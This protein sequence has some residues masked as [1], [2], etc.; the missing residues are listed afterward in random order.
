[1]FRLIVIDT[2][3]QLWRRLP[4]PEKDPRYRRGERRRNRQGEE[5]CIP[6]VA[7]QYADVDTVGHEHDRRPSRL[8]HV[9]TAWG[10]LRGGPPLRRKLFRDEMQTN[11]Y[12]PREAG[13]F[14][15]YR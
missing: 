2:H 1:M 6:R 4:E 5:H 3:E 10:P 7:I 13:S 8:V 12:L 14:L 15:R 9:I 11:G